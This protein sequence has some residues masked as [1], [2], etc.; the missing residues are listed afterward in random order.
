VIQNIVVLAAITFVSSVLTGLVGLITNKGWKGFDRWVYAEGV[1][2]FLI[3]LFALV[4]M[5]GAHGCF[6]TCEILQIS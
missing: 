1:P 6:V 4:I 3:I 2:I 5:L